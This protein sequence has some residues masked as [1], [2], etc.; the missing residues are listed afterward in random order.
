MPKSKSSCRIRWPFLHL[1]FASSDESKRELS[2][3]APCREFEGLCIPIYSNFRHRDKVLGVYRL[4]YSADISRHLGDVGSAEQEMKAYGRVTCFKAEIKSNEP[5]RCSLDR[6]SPLG[7]RSTS[8][9]LP[10]RGVC[11]LR[12]PTYSVRGD[13]TDS[14][15]ALQGGRVAGLWEDDWLDWECTLQMP[16]GAK[17]RDAGPSAVKSPCVLLN[18]Y[19]PTI[20]C[21]TLN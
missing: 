20:V 4:A 15:A 3:S 17:I 18:R 14:R 9:E 19:A 1:L 10:R 13:A 6:S 16:A 5:T 21:S 12:L 7:K 2:C 8:P 11:V